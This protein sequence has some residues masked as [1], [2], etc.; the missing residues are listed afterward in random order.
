MSPANQLTDSLATLRR[1]WRR[2]VLLESAVMLVFAVLL[3]VIAG[4]LLTKMLGVGGATDVA[5]RVVGYALIALS[6][7]PP[8]PP[9]SE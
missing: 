3:A 1:Q 5:I 2:R 9:S 7:C 8:A 6:R 4:A